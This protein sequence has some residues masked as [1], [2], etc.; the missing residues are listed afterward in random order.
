MKKSVFLTLILLPLLS[1][2]AF[3]AVVQW[4]TNGHYY[5]AVLGLLTPGRYLMDR[6][7]SSSA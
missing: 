4:T 1:A 3:G 5:E 2:N 7:A 6:C